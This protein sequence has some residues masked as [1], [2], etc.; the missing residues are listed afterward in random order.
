MT[1]RNYNL[2][3]LLEKYYGQN[4]V[5]DVA[6]YQPEYGFDMGNN[7]STT[8]NNEADAFKHTYMQAQLALLGGR[9]F[10]KLLGDSHERQGADRGQPSGEE[11]MDLWNNHQ[12]REIAKEIIREYGAMQYPF[13]Q[14]IK[15][16]IAQKVMEKMQNGELITHPDDK[17]KYENL[18]NGN[19]TGYATQIEPFTRQQIGRMTSEE[20][21]KNEKAIREQWGKMG[22]PSE[23]DLFKE[24]KKSTS[25]LNGSNDTN[26]KWVTINGNHVL[27]KN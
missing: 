23:Y 26:G 13:S 17:R 5:K 27:I 16:I 22:I 1:N 10:A 11:N 8:W 6:H 20:F 2:I 21:A 24:G 25:K 9:N 7:N 19:P 4:V 15:D 12:G 3:K 18:L 14:K